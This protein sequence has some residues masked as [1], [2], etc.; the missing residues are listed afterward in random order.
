MPEPTPR[1][2]YVHCRQ[3]SATGA[4]GTVAQN[5]GS[6]P[7]KMRAPAG[8]ERREAVERGVHLLVVEGE[9]RQ[10]AL[11]QG[12]AEIAAVGGQHDFA[13]GQPQ[14]QRLVARRVAVGRQ[15]DHRTVAEHIV[16]AID[17]AQFVAEV[18]IA[19]VEAAAAARSGSMPASHSRR[20]TS[21]V[22]FGISALPPQWSKWKCELITRSIFAG[23]AVER[24]ETGGDLLA[25]VIVEIEQRRRDARR[26]ARPGRAGSPDACR[27]R[28]APCPSGAR[29]DRPGSAAGCGPRRLPSAG[30]NR[31]PASR[32]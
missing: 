22:A 2:D 27:Y 7:K 9:A 17:Q 26:A 19:R 5:S 6:W 13:R 25:G 30:R 16:L 1:R 10:A 18:E 29:S 4:C 32:R 31:P 11:A 28:T 23:I 8:F 12:A 14:L 3:T 21:N 15:A 20:C 24:F